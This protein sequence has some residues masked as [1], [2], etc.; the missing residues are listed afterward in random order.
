M[1]M[2]M[3]EAAV[4]YVAG[5]QFAGVVVVVV[6]GVGWGGGGRQHTRALFRC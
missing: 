1:R 2:V 6:V 3:R 5:S 4:S